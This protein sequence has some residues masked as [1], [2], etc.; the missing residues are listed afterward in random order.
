MILAFEN[1]WRISLTSTLTKGYF[2]DIGL[3]RPTEYTYRDYSELTPQSQGSEAK[4]GYINLLMVWERLSRFQL[5]LLETYYDGAAGGLLYFTVDRSN[6]SGAGFDW[7][8]VSGY[9]AVIQY[10]PMPKGRGNI[11]TGTQ[12]RINAIT[13][14]NTPASF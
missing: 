3:P 7:V 13:V 6:G 11:V 4:Q 14:L 9:P 2:R 8:D 10:A 5:Y 1:R 12:W